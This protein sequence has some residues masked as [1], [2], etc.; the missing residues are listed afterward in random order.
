MFI[1]LR[2]LLAHFIGD[3]PLQ[4]TEIYKLRYKGLKGT[5]PHVV[6][7]TGSFILCSWPYLKLAGMWMFIGILSITHLLQ[8]WI[9]IS[10]TKGQKEGFWPY[11]F[12]QILHIAI[13]ATVFFTGL[14]GLKPVEETVSSVAN[15]YNNDRIIVYMIFLIAATYSG[16]YLIET[17]KS[18]FFKTRHHYTPFEKWYGMFERAVTVLIFLPAKTAIIFLMIVP[19]IFCLR[20]PVYTVAKKSKVSINE[21]FISFLEISLSGAIVLVV[22]ITL[23]LF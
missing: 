7:V 11:L 19:F 15:F 3:F 18:S 6:I 5:V 1:F 16:T 22:G 23:Y 2:L 17:L 8:D 4:F 13:I 12:D 21:D 20:L 9:K 14:K 10:Q